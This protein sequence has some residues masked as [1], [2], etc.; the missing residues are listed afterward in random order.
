M[1]NPL[2]ILCEKIVCGNLFFQKAPSG[3][4]LARYVSHGPVCV[5]RDTQIVEL[6]TQ[7]SDLCWLLTAASQEEADLRGAHLY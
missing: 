7:R 4:F 6:S 3:E 2:E 1:T 5:W